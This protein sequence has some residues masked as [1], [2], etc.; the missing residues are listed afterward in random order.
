MT[1]IRKV[2]NMGIKQRIYEAQLEISDLIEEKGIS[3][4]TI[5]R[6]DKGGNTSA[7]NAN[8]IIDFFKKHTGITYTAE[9]LGISIGRH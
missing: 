3:R 6:I 1:H 7:P 5:D 8:K 2:L 9:E 4:A